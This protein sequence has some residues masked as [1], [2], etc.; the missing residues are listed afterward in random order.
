MRFLRVIWQ[1]ILWLNSRLGPA[2]KIIGLIVVLGLIVGGWYL[3][4]EWWTVKAHMPKGGRL[5]PR[6]ERWGA[7]PGL[8]FLWYMIWVVDRG[9]K[10]H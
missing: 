10:S 7:I 6:W 4:R 2:I 1:D 5:A 3:G 9:R 8:V